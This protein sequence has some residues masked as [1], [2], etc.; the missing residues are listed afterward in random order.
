MENL[1]LKADFLSM[2]GLESVFIANSKAKSENV[3]KIH[4]NKISRHQCKQI[5]SICPFTLLASMPILKSSIDSYFELNGNIKRK[6][7]PSNSK[8]QVLV[9]L[10]KN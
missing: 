1:H 9:Y 3:N 5:I 7:M 8:T 2:L 10:S 4:P 6:S